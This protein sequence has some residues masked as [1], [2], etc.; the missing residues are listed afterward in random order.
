[1]PGWRSNSGELLLHFGVD[2][3]LQANCE[4][5]DNRNVRLFQSPDGDFRVL[6]GQ[7]WSDREAIN[8][9]PNL[10][11]VDAG[12]FTGDGGEEAVFFFSGYN[13]DGYVLYY[14]NFRKAVRFGW[15]YH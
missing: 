15:S 10:K 4:I 14:D 2:P 12:D 5:R 8:F 7:E 13:F 1:M 3:R 9:T 11:L 6:P